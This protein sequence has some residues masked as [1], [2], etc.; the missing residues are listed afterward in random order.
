MTTSD[1]EVL[2]KDLF[3]ERYKD[4]IT[5]NITGRIKKQ[6]CSIMDEFYCPIQY[7]PDRYNSWTEN[8]SALEIANK[9]LNEYLEETEDNQKYLNDKYMPAPYLFDLLEFQYNEIYDTEKNEF[10]KKINIVFKTNHI[11]FK[12]TKRGLIEQRL[13]YNI[14]TPNFTKAIDS[15]E[16]D[17]KRLIDL[18]IKKHS[19]PDEQSHKDATEKIWDAFERAKTYYKDLN[20]KQ[21]ANKI[22]NNIVGEQPIL[23]TVIE[24]EFKE[25]TDIGNNFCIRH[26]EADKIN[27]A[28]IRHYDYF[29]NR[30]LSLL[31]LIIS[32]I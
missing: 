13:D 24:K 17:L 19:L 1:K 14:S 15:K 2:Y 11:P 29:Y 28:D 32:F 30:C 27:I 18:A 8:T 4:N 25:L 16:P 21:S 20:K 10:L 5:N 31:I 23:K 22:V 3:S 6:I 26:H 7:Q 9:N 12:L